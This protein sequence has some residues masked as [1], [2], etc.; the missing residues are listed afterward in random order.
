MRKPISKEL[1][2]K[3]Y[4]KYDGHCAYCGCKL[5]YKDMQ[6][7]HVVAFGQVYYSRDSKQVQQMIANDEIN[8][9]ENL[10]PS[11]RQCNFYK[12]INNIDEF[13]T[14]IKDMLSRTC[15]DNFQA[16]LAM[17]YG[18]IEYHSWD[19]KFYFEKKQSNTR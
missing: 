14:K 19:G 7:D 5:D 15:I 1:R 3:V 11:C 6:V 13:R 17:K 18:I 12:G 8:G 9:A 2:K 16:R 4:E 10:M